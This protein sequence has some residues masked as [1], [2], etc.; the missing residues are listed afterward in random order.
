MCTTED[1]ARK[2]KEISHTS[3]HCWVNIIFPGRD[4]EVSQTSGEGRRIPTYYGSDGNECQ[5]SQPLR[6]RKRQWTNRFTY[7][8]GAAAEEERRKS[9]VHT[10]S[11]NLY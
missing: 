2:K 4:M 11:K 9:G 1:H 6:A 3:L 10:R 7:K 5:P 8:E